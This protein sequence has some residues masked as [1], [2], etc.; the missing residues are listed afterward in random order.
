MFLREWSETPSN[1]CTANIYSL[2][3]LTFKLAIKTVNVKLNLFYTE[4]C[5]TVGPYYTCCCVTCFCSFFTTRFTKW[6]TNTCS[7]VLCLKLRNCI[8]ADLCLG[9]PKSLKRLWRC[10][11][12]YIIIENIINRPTVCSGIFGNNIEIKPSLR[13]G[14]YNEP[15]SG[16]RKL[17]EIK[18]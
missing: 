4:S 17:A 9:P 2:H 8:E 14:V 6:H 13:L 16:C 11:R 1:T 7:E 12:L 18:F 15:S 10:V 3:N 5:T